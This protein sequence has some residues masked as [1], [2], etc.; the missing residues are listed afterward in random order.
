MAITCHKWQLDATTSE[1]GR[2]YTS[3]FKDSKVKDTTT[4]ETVPGMLWAVFEKCPVYGGKVVSANLIRVA[5]G[6]SVWPPSTRT[7]RGATV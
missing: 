3:L 2:L 4:H 1:A 7:L 5:A 6:R